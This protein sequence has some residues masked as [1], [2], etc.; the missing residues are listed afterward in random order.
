MLEFST[1]GLHFQFAQVIRILM[2][3]QRSFCGSHFKEKGGIYLLDYIAW[4]TIGIA[5]LVRS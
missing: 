4:K 2:A 3:D 5:G 1:F